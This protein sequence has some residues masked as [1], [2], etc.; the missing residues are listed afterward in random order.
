LTSKYFNYSGLPGIIYI[1]SSDIL[2]I[3]IRLNATLNLINKRIETG[4]NNYFNTIDIYF[5]D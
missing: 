2:L 5:G 3:I 4:E 1:I